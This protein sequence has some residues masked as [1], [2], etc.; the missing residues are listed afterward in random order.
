MSDT[1]VAVGEDGGFVNE[2]PTRELGVIPILTTRMKSFDEMEWSDL[3]RV[4][5]RAAM[6]PELYLRRLGEGKSLRVG[7]G[8]VGSDAFARLVG[9]TKSVNA[10]GFFYGFT[11]QLTGIPPVSFEEIP[12]DPYEAF[13]VDLASLIPE[14]TLGRVWLPSVEEITGP[15]VNKWLDWYQFHNDQPDR[16]L[17]DGFGVPTGYWTRSVDDD[18]ERLV[19]DEY[20][21]VSKGTT[22]LYLP[23]LMFTVTLDNQIIER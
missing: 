23:D 15:D 16:V 3:A 12:A 8:S 10:D 22:G 6:S 14:T 1:Y 9:L 7:I 13:D 17:T 21:R 5:D 11:F 18:G 4:S 19:I 20:G 2:S